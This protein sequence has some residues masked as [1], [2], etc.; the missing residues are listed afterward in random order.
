MLSKKSQFTGIALIITS[1]VA[2]CFGQMFWKL[3]AS[4]GNLVILAGGFVLYGL[5]ALLMMI[6]FRFGKLS[7]L[8]PMM[9][10]GYVLSLF[11]GVYTFAEK[12]TLSKVG[13]IICI[14]AGLIFLA[15][16]DSGGFEK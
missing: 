4:D 6:S 15:V 14:L 5:G 8:H 12:I 10:V 16:S 7:V 9:S 11:V 2:V 13:G 1:A 3:G